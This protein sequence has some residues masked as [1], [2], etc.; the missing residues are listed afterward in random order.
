MTTLSAPGLPP[1]VRTSTI[2]RELKVRGRTAKLEA[3]VVFVL[4]GVVVV[5]NRLTMA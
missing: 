2:D 4:V 5:T 1:T 3:L